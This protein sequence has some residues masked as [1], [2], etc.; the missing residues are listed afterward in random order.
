MIALVLG[1]GLVLDE[2]SGWVL[3]LRVFQRLVVGDLSLSGVLLYRNLHLHHLGVHQF[4]TVQ[5][6]L[7]LLKF[8]I[9]ILRM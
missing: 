5:H 8:N 4:L 7:H 2:K 6:Q 3:G 1:A 9:K